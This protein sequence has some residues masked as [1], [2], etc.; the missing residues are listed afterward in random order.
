MN[1]L[2]KEKSTEYLK[3]IE[4][5]QSV[6]EER[7]RLRNRINRLEEAHKVLNSIYMG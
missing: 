4:D 3:L 6:V 5:C 7:E 1:Q 2:W